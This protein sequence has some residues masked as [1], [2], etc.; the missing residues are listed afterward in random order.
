MGARRQPGVSGAPFLRPG[1]SAKRT[2]AVVTVAYVVTGL[3]WVFVSDIALYRWVDH[4]ALVSRFETAKGW[5]FVLVSGVLIL[6]VTFAT[7]LEL[8]R[9]QRLAS[10][11][12]ES[13]GDGILLLGPNRTVAHANPAALRIL[14]SELGDLVGMDARA[15][16][17]RF[18][19]AYPSG[20]L[21]P[22]DHFVSQRVF[23][24][25]DPL[26]YKAV[27]RVDEDRDRI[28]LANAAGVRSKPDQPADWVVTVLHDITT[29]DQLDQLRNRF[30]AAA[31]HSLKT[32]V[33]TIKAHAQVLIR[34]LPP[35][36]RKAV[37]AIERQCDRIDRLVQNLLV[38]A[39]ERSETLELHPTALEVG[40]MIERIATE[41]V[42]S[43]HHEVRAEVAGAPRA[44]ADPERLSLAI[45]NLVYEASRLSPAESS[46]KISAGTERSHVTVEVSY[47]PMDGW[48]AASTLYDEFDDIGI[49]RMVTD[50]I[51]EAHA[52]SLT[53]VADRPFTTR[54]E[55]PE[56]TWEAERGGE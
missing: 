12:I 30:F 18:R 6:G 35:D 44:Y 37:V 23:E 34:K 24:E 43:H 31:A 46:I 55:L 20:A 42:W 49:G 19:V 52:G 26:R 17:Q 29:S 53:R 40:P 47:E 50:T 10:T 13:I 15:F 22:P 9:A 39:R 11:V 5:I 51:V 8:A 16:A 45:R 36:H 33:T 25:P 2:A 21:V 4:P 38:L 41:P 1:I 48:G 14:N 56:A 3:L 28:V 27:L 54:I 7:S 32:P